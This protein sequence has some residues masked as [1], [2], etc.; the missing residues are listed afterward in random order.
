MEEFKIAL[1][2]KQLTSLIVKKSY[3]RK[4]ITLAEEKTKKQTH[5][6]SKQLD[7]KAAEANNFNTNIILSGSLKDFQILSFL[8]GSSTTAL[9]APGNSKG[10]F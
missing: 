9:E 3:L 4:I 10:S 1:L 6:L 7:L 5:Y 2:F 8:A